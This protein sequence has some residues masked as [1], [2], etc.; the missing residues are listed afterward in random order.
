MFDQM[1]AMGALAGLLKDKERVRE[2]AEAVKDRLEA[3]HVVGEA[4]GGA[5]RV[6]MSG[7]M[8]VVATVMD[9][10]MLMGMAADEQSRAYAQA[11]ITEA[12]NNAM[13]KAQVMIREEVARAAEELGINEIPG[14]DRLMDSF[15]GDLPGGQD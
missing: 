15:G 2:I 9:P 7:K 8:R 10:A 13:E 4:G 5:V 12:T 14:L 3:S 11:L 6:T 1:K